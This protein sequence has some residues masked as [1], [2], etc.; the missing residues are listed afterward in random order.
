MRIL[1][2]EDDLEVA[3]GLYRALTASGMRVDLARDGC[4][5]L[6]LALANGYAAIVLDLMLPRVD[7][8]RV[9]QVLRERRDATPI[10]MITARNSVSDRVRGLENGAEDRKSVV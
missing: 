4:D 3:G 9:C 10:L 5:G 6:E 1:L 7:G 2:V 8:M